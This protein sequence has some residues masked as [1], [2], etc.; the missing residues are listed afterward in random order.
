MSFAECFDPYGFVVQSTGTVRM[1]FF[2]DDAFVT[3]NQLFLGGEI[4]SLQEKDTCF[5][6]L[7]FVNFVNH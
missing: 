4:A 5:S 2:G 6:S 3:L 1:C 7:E